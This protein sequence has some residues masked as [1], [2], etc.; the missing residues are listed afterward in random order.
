MHR[1]YQLKQIYKCFYCLF[2]FVACSSCFVWVREKSY[3]FN[4]NILYTKNFFPEANRSSLDFTFSISFNLCSLF[5]FFSLFLILC[6]VSF[7]LVSM[8]PNRYECFWSYCWWKMHC[9]EMER[10]LWSRSVLNLQH[11]SSA[12]LYNVFQCKKN[13]EEKK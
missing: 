6:P 2:C 10:T 11:H 13:Q 9:F 1:Y 7:V 12:N 3:Y 4:E 5:L 8:K